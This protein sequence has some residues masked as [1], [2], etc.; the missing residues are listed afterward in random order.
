MLALEK[1]N[2]I[3]KLAFSDTL[4]VSTWIRQKAFRFI[5][6]YRSRVFSDRRLN[7]INGVTSKGKKMS[8][9]VLSIHAAMAAA[10]IHCSDEEL[11]ISEEE[12]EKD[13]ELVQVVKEMINN[14]FEQ[15]GTGPEQSTFEIDAISKWTQELHEFSILLT[16]PPVSTKS[17][18]NDGGLNLLWDPRHDS[19]RKL[20]GIETIKKRD[21]IIESNDIA[22]NARNFDNRMIIDANNNSSSAISIIDTMSG[23]SAYAKKYQS[24]KIKDDATELETYQKIIHDSNSISLSVEAAIERKRHRLTAKFEEEFEKFKETVDSQTDNMISN[25]SKE[26]A[27]RIEE[28]QSNSSTNSDNH[29]TTFDF[30]AYSANHSAAINATAEMNNLSDKNNGDAVVSVSE[31]VYVA[32]EMNNSNDANTSNFQEVDLTADTADD[33]NA[34]DVQEMDTTVDTTDEA[35]TTDVQEM[36]TAADIADDEI[37]T[38]DLHEMDATADVADDDV[39]NSDLHEMDTTAD[40]IEAYADAS[41]THE[42]DTTAD[43]VDDDFNTATAVDSNLTARKIYQPG[44][45][46]TV[47]SRSWPGINKPGGAAH[48]TARNEDGTYNVRY[49]LTS[50]KDKN[51]P[52]DYV[53]DLYQMLKNIDDVGDNTNENNVGDFDEI[54]LELN[55]DQI[56]ISESILRRQSRHRSC[57]S[58]EPLQGWPQGSM[59]PDITWRDNRFCCLCRE[60]G[61]DNICGNTPIA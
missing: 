15:H 19:K 21:V 41:E 54:R 31:H 59:G 11:G 57:I 35:N 26:I 28:L 40:A 61:E 7:I 55:N 16:V 45:A 17:V 22:V 18:D 25:L 60:N 38:S 12:P 34:T 43:D 8:L 56:L 24:Q 6:M 10:F 13:K 30:N 5:A 39:N 27:C 3:D 33:A 23:D 50:S 37:N 47:L 58:V 29:N 32:D 48:V 14:V 1:N 52:A 51:V 44:D 9:P 2:N 36:D 42:M 20:L 4:P 49:I 53:S 46:V